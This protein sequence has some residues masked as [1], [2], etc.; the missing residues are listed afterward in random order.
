MS[1]FEALYGTKPRQLCIP[2]EHRSS[3]DCVL[4]FQINREAMNQI[5]KDAIH[6]AQN[7]FK[8]FADRKRHE[9]SFAVGDY[10]YLKLQPYR[11][12]SVAVRRHL[13]L[14]HKYY[15][16]YKILERV[17]AVAYKL[18]LPADS[19]I[20]PVFHASLL[21]KKVGSDYRVTTFLPRLGPE[22]QFLVYPVKLLNKRMIKRNNAA[23]T[24]WLLQWSHSVPEDASW[25]DANVI[26]EQFPDFNP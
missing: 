8:Q 2:S 26:Q 21:K 20:H 9:V 5:L 14:A 11:Q 7:R 18:Q 6:T 16:P 25:E 19:Q 24:Q 23:V 1:P 3:V 4:E 17:G 22:G 12:L 15:G 10:V 13:K